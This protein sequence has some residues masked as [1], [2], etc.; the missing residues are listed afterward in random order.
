MEK[1]T[2]EK[3][4]EYTPKLI[5]I[6]SFEIHSKCPQCQ[7]EDAQREKEYQELQERIREEERIEQYKN[8]LLDAGITQRYIEERKSFDFNKGVALE[9]KRYFDIE[10]NQSLLLLGNTGVGKTF[11]AF[12]LTQR[13]MKH[14]QNVKYL[15][16]QELTEIFKI[17]RYGQEVVYKSVENLKNLI[18]DLDLLIVDEIDDAFGDEFSIQTMKH[19]VSISYDDKKRIIFIGNCTAKDLKMHLDPKTISRLYSYDI[20]TFGDNFE[21]LRKDGK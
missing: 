10:N 16:L 1:I 4:G 17:R 3:H 7:L 2:C 8:K 6:G 15:K 21:D 18:F 12:R 13:L 9:L 14:G 19:L 5:R 11:F 20:Q